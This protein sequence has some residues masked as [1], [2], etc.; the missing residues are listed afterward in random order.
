MSAIFSMVIHAD[1]TRAKARTSVPCVSIEFL[2]AGEC[3]DIFTTSHELA[4]LICTGIN[5]AITKSKRAKALSA[6]TEADADL[7]GSDCHA[8]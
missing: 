7:I 5:D 1:P 8:G 4:D 2:D 3:I 6:L